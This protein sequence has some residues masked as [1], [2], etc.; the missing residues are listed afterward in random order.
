LF[1]YETNKRPQFRWSRPADAA[2]PVY[3]PVSAILADLHDAF[4]GAAAAELAAGLA[5]AAAVVPAA[6]RSA[7]ARTI[8]FFM[9]SAL[10]FFGVLL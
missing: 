8:A 6:T 1:Q 5:N 2:G 9:K 4:A 7:N 3:G 10:L